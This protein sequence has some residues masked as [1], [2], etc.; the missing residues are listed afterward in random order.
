MLNEIRN[1]RLRIA[2]ATILLSCLT[3]GGAGTV[4]ANSLTSPGEQPREQ[5]ELPD[6]G[7]QTPSL[8]KTKKAIESALPAANIPSN[9]PAETETAIGVSPTATNAP[10]AT[11]ND[12]AVPLSIPEASS[13]NDVNEILVASHPAAVV[14]SLAIN[15]PSITPNAESESVAVRTIPSLEK[16]RPQ[17]VQTPL[18]GQPAPP[19]TEQQPERLEDSTPPSLPVPSRTPSTPSAP[20]P[21]GT[22]ATP[23]TLPAPAPSGTQAA[24]APDPQVLVAELAIDG[25]QDPELLNEIYRVISTRAG[26]PTTRTIL[27]EDVNQIFATGYFSNVTVLPEDTPLGVRITFK[28]EP[29]PILNR[30]VIQTIPQREG[31]G[32]LPQEKVDE[33]FQNQ[34]GKILNLRRFQAGILRLNDWYKEQGYDLAQVVGAPE[35]GRDGTV[36]LVVAEGNIED[37]RVRFF[38]DENEP[39][40]GVTRPFIVTREIELKP[41]DVFNRQTAQRDLERVFGLGIFDDVKFSFSPGSDPS[42][43]I[44]NVDV[45][46]ASTGSVAAGAGI[47]SASGFFGT[48]SYQQKNVGGNNQTFSAEA[49]LGTREFLF[50]LSFTDPWIATH[51]NRLSYTVNAFRRRSISLIFD[52]GNPDIRLPNGDR[53]RIVRTGG[54]ITFGQ[55]LGGSPFEQSPWYVSAGL[56][57][58]GVSVEDSRGDRSPRDELGNLLSF[59]DSGKDQMLALHFGASQDLRNNPFQPTSGSLLRLAMDQTIP[60]G[61]GNILMSRLR[62]SYSYYIPVEFTNFTP[63]P[64]ALAFNIQ[65]GTIFGDLPPYEA[66]AIG[67]ANSVRGY[68][69]GGVGSGRSYLQFTAEYRFPLFA[70]SRFGIGGALF[71]D[72]G[73]DLGTGS[74][75]PG[76]PAV[77]RN[78]PGDGLGYGLGVRVQSPLGPIR[79]DYG[80]NIDGGSRFHFGIGERF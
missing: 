67:G 50:D 23:P 34:Y 18:P 29:N 54:G 27:Q 38:N 56:D 36:T 48:A 53:P 35:V 80:F 55:P 79:I 39:V 45:N 74:D 40:D 4:R 68:T 75:V 22:Q 72:Y 73:T 9:L 76:K 78:K 51:P 21:S 14:E 44:V 10:T 28:V 15:G 7:S 58:Q 20:A 65:G 5:W 2:I 24:P 13:N 6:E 60:V 64:E 33:I 25:T 37:I 42:K 3:F 63:G 19:E 8:L 49:Q 17:L 43:V 32:V 41:G 69:E 1:L 66:F 16:H 47:S 12:A 61:S 59:S 70:I 57:F 31:E 77:I 30:V 26:R 71:V 11:P 52:E 62:G 46:E